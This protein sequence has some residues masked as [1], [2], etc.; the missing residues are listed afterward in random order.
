MRPLYSGATPAEGAT[1]VSRGPTFALSSF[2][3]RYG[4]EAWSHW[5][6]DWEVWAVLAPLMSGKWG[7]KLPQEPRFSRFAGSL[8]GLFWSDDTMGSPFVKAWA[9]AI[10]VCMPV[11]ESSHPKGE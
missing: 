7:S 10:A 5:S 1:G 9:Y 11:T 3:H 8:F 2:K 4:G 6:T